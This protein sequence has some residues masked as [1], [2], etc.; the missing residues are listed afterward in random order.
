MKTHKANSLSI[1]S[2]NKSSSGFDMDESV[3]YLVYS[4]TPT[5]RHFFDEHSAS[6]PD[7][8]INSNQDGN[9]LMVKAVGTVPDDTVDVKQLNN[10]VLNEKEMEEEEEEY[11]VKEGTAENEINTSESD[12]ESENTRMEEKHTRLKK[13]KLSKF[14]KKRFSWNNKDKNENKLSVIRS[15]SEVDLSKYDKE[16][17]LSPSLGRNK[18]KMFGSTSDLHDVVDKMCDNEQNTSSPNSPAKEV[19]FFKGSL[20][21]SNKF[22]TDEKRG[23]MVE[24]S[25]T[26]VNVL[27]K[28]YYLCLLLLRIHIV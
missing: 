10:L 7:I 15:K 16:S 17:K 21:R 23:S 25:N 3:S 14:L 12:V 19:K 20:E 28:D 27:L 6:L 26:L 22:Y 1:G 5:G 8:L 9:A 24:V 11:K 2:N 18:Y 4:S 13:P